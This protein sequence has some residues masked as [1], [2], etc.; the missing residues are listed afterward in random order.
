[1]D[2]RPI[3]LEEHPAT[4]LPAFA[5]V[6]LPDT[7]VKEARDRVRAALQSAGYE[8]PARRITVNPAPADLPKESGRFGAGDRCPGLSG[9]HAAGGVRAFVRAFVRTFRGRGRRCAAGVPSAGR[10]LIS[11]P[12]LSSPDVATSHT[13]G[14]CKKNVA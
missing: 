13:Y 8:L 6:G 10:G 2:A 1:M 3:A 9:G 4:G 7:E 5:I 14:R 12:A 11:P